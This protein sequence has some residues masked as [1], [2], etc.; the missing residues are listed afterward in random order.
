MIIINLADIVQRYDTRPILDG[1]SWEI[2]SGQKIGLVGANGVGK[3]TVL[4]LIAGEIAPDRGS[5]FRLKGLRIGYLAQEP[6]L[7][8]TRTVWDEALGADAVLLAVEQRLHALEAS[9]AD[10]AVYGEEAR[11]QRALAALAQAQAE[12]ERLDGY[13]H[14][15]RA[16]EVL[17]SLGFDELDFTLPVSALSGGQKKMLGLAKLLATSCDLLLLDEPDNHLDLAG[18]AHLERFVGTF[19]GTVVVVSHDRYLLDEMVTTIAEVEEGRLTTYS[20]NYTAYATERQLRLLRQQQLYQAQQKEIARI[21]AAI[22]RFEYWA[23]IVVN[24]RHIRQARSRRKMLERMDKIDKPILERR[25]MSLELEGWRGSHKVLEIADLSKRF[26]NATSSRWVLQGLNLLLWH[27]ERVGLLGANGAGK[28]VLLRCILG[29]EEPTSGIIKI[30]PSIRVGYYAQSHET[31][32]PEMTLLDEVRRAKPL[33]EGQAVSFLG[34]F[35]FPY[36]MVRQ[37][38][39]DLSGGERSRLQLA[40][41]MLA[42]VN[43]LLLDEPTNNLDIPSCEV[44]EDALDEFEGTMLA[45]SHDRYFLD[46]TVDRIVELDGGALAEYPGDYTYYCRE[47]ARLSTPDGRRAESSA[48]QYRIR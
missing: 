26:E 2:N 22:A 33:S 34:R 29:M 46:R 44:M 25:Q 35:L 15:S 10:P 31:L 19:A 28:S 30:G 42:D 9:L 38:V 20:G 36:R 12:F 41:L 18:K 3:S 11:L 4:R 48:R 8:S 24:E 37:R 16:R 17:L 39:A 43:F 7:D 47:K 5:I 32:S 27:G 21:E 40:K 14:E 23:S 6:V 45:I 13:R 1:L